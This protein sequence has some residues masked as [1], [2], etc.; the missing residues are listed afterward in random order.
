[1]AALEADGLAACRSLAALVDALAPP[2]TVWL[3]LPSGAPVDAVLAKLE[4]RLAPGDVVLEGGNSDFRR[5]QTHA[6]RLA[7]RGVTLLDVGVSGGIW[8][9]QDGCG[10]LVGGDEAAVAR[11]AAAFDAVAAPDG[12]AHVG[13]AGAGHYAKMIHNAIEYGVMQAY[14]EGYELLTAAPVEIDAARTV[15]T[16]NIACSIRAWL[17]GHLAT[18]LA[19]NPQLEGVPGRVGD[20][21]QARWSVE[22]AVDLGVPV[23]AIAAALFA[24]LGSQQ[25]EAPAMQA[26]AALRRQVGG[27][28]A[29]AAA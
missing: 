3:M 21:G 22:Q 9:L 28:P 17:L 4:G 19:D 14:A 11:A 8:G 1:V 24:R 18:V 26:I 16:W 13:L 23:P 5:S 10:L 7:A 25:A 12:W 20:S 6:K 27:H 2:R 29:P 15:A